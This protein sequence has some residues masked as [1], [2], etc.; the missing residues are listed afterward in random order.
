MGFHYTTII[1]AEA[2]RL[3]PPATR[4]EIHFIRAAGHTVDVRYVKETGNRWYSVDGGK[5]M[6]A[7]QMADK[8]RHLF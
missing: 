5:P 1:G 8:F 7:G 3:A 6:R 2:E 4:A